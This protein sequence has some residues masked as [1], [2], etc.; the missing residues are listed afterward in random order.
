MLECLQ[1]IDPS[2]YM[3]V[4]KIVANKYKF[5]QERVEDTEIYSVC[6]LELVKIASDYSGEDF[7]KYAYCALRNAIID[8][9]R[10][11]NRKKRKAKFEFIDEERWFS[12]NRKIENLEELDFTEI[13]SQILSTHPDDNE[14]DVE[15]KQLLK[16]V[17][18]EGSKVADIAAMKKVSRQCIYSRIERICTKLASR[19]KNDLNLNAF[20]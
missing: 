20:L 2:T 13:S 15:D 4:A 12:L 18:I 5:S 14:Y 1:K 6:L 16:A 11:N 8:H 10:R 17:Y 9:L 19:H 7:A 3:Y